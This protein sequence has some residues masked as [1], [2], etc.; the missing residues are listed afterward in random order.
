MTLRKTCGFSNTMIKPG[1]FNVI[2]NTCPMIIKKKPVTATKRVVEDANNENDLGALKFST[3]VA[4]DPVPSLPTRSGINEPVI[5]TFE[6]DDVD[7]SS[8][9]LTL[10][11]VI[12][13]NGYPG[14][15]CLVQN[16]FVEASV[17]RHLRKQ[18]NFAVVA[19]IFLVSRFSSISVR[20]FVELFLTELVCCYSGWSGRGEDLSQ[21]DIYGLGHRVFL[22]GFV[23]ESLVMN[24]YEMRLSEA[25]L[26]NVDKWLL[27]SVE[28][29]W[30]TDE[31]AFE[32]LAYFCRSSPWKKI[33]TRAYFLL[34]V[35]SLD[36]EH[37]EYASRRLELAT[38]RREVIQLLVRKYEILT[39]MAK[40]KL[41]R[42]RDSRLQFV[43]IDTNL[44]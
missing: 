23:V 14:L 22:P 35:K 25:T 18:K 44:Q 15:D 24:T 29:I 41:W 40:D 1:L 30:E 31:V 3:A 2:S 8:V 4:L 39:L 33:C 34:M 27:P 7:I 36:P 17:Y 12:P 16:D 42:V 11:N 19:G 26:R 28:T 13:I 43:L 9:M 5:F 6:S 10:A 20:L 21:K 37:P 32:E 38:F